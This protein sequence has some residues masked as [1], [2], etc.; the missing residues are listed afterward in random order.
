MSARDWELTL[1]CFG[2]GGDVGVTRELF[3]VFYHYELIRET[4]YHQWVEDSSDTVP[5][6]QTAILE[7]GAFL[8]WLKEAEEEDDDE[9]DDDDEEHRADD[10]APA[11]PAQPAAV[12]TE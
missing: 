12:S 6:K 11:P 5:G 2:D 9:E 10:S 3:C 4:T 1:R 7:V 8:Q